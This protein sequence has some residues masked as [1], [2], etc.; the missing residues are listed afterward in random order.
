MVRVSNLQSPEFVWTNIFCRAPLTQ[1]TPGINR[2][3]PHFAQKSAD[4]LGTNQ[5]AKGFD[6]IDHAQNAFGRMLQKLF[7]H[8]THYLQIF[9]LFFYRL[10][11]KAAPVHV[12]EFALSF[13]TQ[14][15]SWGNYFLEGFSIPNCS[16]TLLQKS[17]STSSRPIFSY[18]IFSRFA[19]SSSGALVEK[20]SDPRERNSCFHLDIICG[21]RPKRFASSPSVSCSLI[22]SMA[23]WALN[24][25]LYFFLVFFIVSKFNGFY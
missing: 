21:W 12:Q 15:W 24:V 20:I 13:Y 17:T 1:I 6:K 19:A 22:A 5:N 25:A 9:R 3:Y 23:T 7:I 16:D 18:N 4:T 10:V 11:I 2:H 8:Q 14:V